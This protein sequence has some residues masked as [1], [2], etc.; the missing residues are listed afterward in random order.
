MGRRCVEVHCNAAPHRH[1]TVC[2]PAP[3][4]GIPP[5]LPQEPGRQCSWL[6]GGLEMCMLDWRC[7]RRYH[8]WE[9]GTAHPW[10]WGAQAAAGAGLPDE[11][12]DPRHVSVLG[13]LFV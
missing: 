1:A 2:V 3:H 12:D 5:P 4:R 7:D 11:G 10:P 9:L 8:A 6:L 13:L